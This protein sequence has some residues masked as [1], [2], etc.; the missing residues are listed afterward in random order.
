MLD[1]RKLEVLK[2]IVTDYVASQEPVG[3]KALVER[4][5]LNVSPATVRNDMAVLEEI[6]ADGSLKLWLASY[7]EM[8]FDEAVSA[9][10]SEFVREKMR[11][12]LNFPRW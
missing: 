1:E 10:I 2:A 9:E 6:Y 12:R 7:G 11:A 8:F 4:H 5:Q 3:S